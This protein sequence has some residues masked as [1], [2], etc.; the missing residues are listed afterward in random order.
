MNAHDV[1]TTRVVAVSPD[2]RTSKIAE[3]LF[4]N[5][6]SAAPVIDATGTPIGMVSEGDL[7]EEGA[8]EGRRDWWLVPLAGGTELNADYLASP[9]APERTARAIMAAP[10]VTVSEDTDISEIAWLLAAYC[11]KR[12]PVVSDGRIIGI[13][14]CADLRR[15]LARGKPKPAARGRRNRA[16]D[17]QLA[18][19]AIPASP[20]SRSSADRLSPARA[21]SWRA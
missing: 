5:G 1:M 9:R 15:G 7:I 21:G 11:I 10:V 20:T 13:V 6:I 3:L 17:I 16:S 12:V 2:T 19:Q 4:E 18:R 8:R 14:S